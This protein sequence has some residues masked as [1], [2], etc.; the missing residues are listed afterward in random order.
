MT[1]S[2][3]ILELRGLTCE[4]RSGGLLGGALLRAVDS[5]DLSVMPGDA[6]ALVGESGSGKT[7]LARCALRLLVPTAGK[8]LFDGVALEEL[9]GPALR[10]KRREFQMIFQDA[11]ASMDPRMTVQSIIAEPFAAQGLGSPADR[12]KWVRELACSVALD[13][14]ALARHPEELSGGQQQRVVIAR[15]LALRPRL[16]LADEPVAALDP[17]VQAQIL[18]LLADLRVQRGLTL[19]LISH[20]LAVVRHLCDRVVVM[21]SGRIVED[22]AA[23]LFFAGPKHPYSRALLSSAP[24]DIGE[25][26][27]Y[28][29]APEPLGPLPSAG[30]A[31]HPRCQ[32]VL[33]RCRCEVPPLSVLGAENKVA[34][35]L[36]TSSGQLS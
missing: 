6:V 5:V 34:C 24:S 12:A 27:S 4:F 19:V 13:D 10:R 2:Q 30:C 29:T 14:S 7:T 20:S 28:S 15:A 26:R 8:V 9:D 3:P 16:L 1:A 23:E 22:A 33:P 35:F 17:S 36:Y 25:V 11:L 31:F 21:Y 18:N 32:E